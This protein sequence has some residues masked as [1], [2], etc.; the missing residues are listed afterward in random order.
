MV[1]PDGR[2]RPRTVDPIGVL[3]VD[4]HD[5]FRSVLREVVQ[6]TDGFELV[7]EAESGEAAL[8]AVEELS[9]SLVIMDKRM[10]GMGGIEA[11]RLLAERHPEIVVIITSI[12]EPR[13]TTFGGR[14]A[15]FIR[16]QELS[17]RLLRKVWAENRV[18]V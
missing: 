12:E 5:Y 1:D 15:V 6:A 4:D 18:S 17:P 7:G 16:K 2:E 11:G 3:A 14:A 13:P 9:P 10:P 8:A